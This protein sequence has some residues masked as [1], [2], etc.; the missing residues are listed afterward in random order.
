[1]NMSGL[2]YINLSAIF[3]IF[4]KTL[5]DAYFTIHFLLFVK[6]NMS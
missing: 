2:E 6:T 3:P 4:N 1:M 5:F